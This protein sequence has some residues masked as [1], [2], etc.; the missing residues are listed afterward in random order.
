MKLY[1]FVLIPLRPFFVRNIAANIRFGNTAGRRI[2]SQ[3]FVRYSA[4]VLADEK[5]RA[6]E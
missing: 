6:L 4:S 5:R 2:Y 1:G 3:L